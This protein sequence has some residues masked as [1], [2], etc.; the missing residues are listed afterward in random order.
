MGITVLNDKCLGC[1]LCVPACPFGAITIAERKAV[2]GDACTLCGACVPVC[3]FNA[4]DLRQE[5]VATVDKSSFSGVWVFAEQRQGRLADVAFELLGEGRQLAET[6]RQPL[7]AVL[8]GH[9]VE[10][11]AGELFAFGADR[12][13]LADHEALGGFIEDSY[14]QVLVEMARAERPNMILLGATAIGRSLAPR[15]AARLGTGLTADCTGLSADAATGDLHQTRPAFGGNVMATILCPNHRP[16][17]ATVRP[18]VFCPL[19]KDEKPYGRAGPL[20][21]VQGRLRPPDEDPRGPARRGRE[22]QPD[23]GGHH[24]L[25]R[26]GTGR[27][28]EPLP[29]QGSGRRAGRDSGRLPRG[30]RRGLDRLS[31]S[32]RAD[33]QDGAAQDLHRLRHPRRR[34]APGRHAVIRCDRRHK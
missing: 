18:R 29:G 25:R 8:L 34:A 28:K 14:T 20:G 10:H 26:P 30:G 31:A 16:Q 7:V 27:P 23:R 5:T 33:R 1:K 19:P 11:L 17:M 32:G 15:V 4:I 21:P 2:I 9:G 24:R 12:V 13:Y 3:K 6:V 22:G